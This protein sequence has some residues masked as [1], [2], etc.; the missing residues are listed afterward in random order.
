MKCHR[1][2]EL[3]SASMP[4]SFSQTGKTQPDSNMEAWVLK[5]VQDDGRGG[6]HGTL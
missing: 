4:R 5:Q 2:A 6:S 1:H 3:V